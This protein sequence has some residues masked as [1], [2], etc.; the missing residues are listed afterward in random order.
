MHRYNGMNGRL[1]L[2]IGLVAL[3]FLAGC[4]QVMDV[5]NIIPGAQVEEGRP[6]SRGVAAMPTGGEAAP[7]VYA[8]ETGLAIPMVE[9]SAKTLQTKE[10]TVTIEVKTGELEGKLKQTQ[11]LLKSQG[12]L[13][14][15]IVYED[16]TYQ[17]R[18]LLT[19][20]IEPARFD[21]V[22]DEL[23][24]V[25]EVKGTNVNIE[26]VTRQHADLTIR[27]NNKQVELERLYQ[28]Y[29]RSESVEDLLQVESE[30]A[31]VTTELEQLK[32]DKEY[33][34]GRIARSTLTVELYE[35]VAPTEAREGSI[36]I[37]VNEGQLETTVL[38]LKEAV[39]RYDGSVKSIQFSETTYEKSYVLVASIVPGQRDGLV[40]DL[41]KLGK[42]TFMGTSQEEQNR[43]KKSLVVVTLT[44][45]KPAVQ[46]SFFVPLETLIQ[47]FFGALSTGVLILAGLTGFLLPGL[48]IVGIGYWFY[49]RRR[50]K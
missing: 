29:N 48:V 38:K 50:R 13:V 26:D 2:L 37:S 8:P 14:T 31:R 49:R 43:P 16:Y 18:Y 3:L 5:N 10:G 33:L 27:L 36:G 42:V 11:L 28:L 34:D 12:A 46:T 25:G 15:A 9:A 4:A 35:N 30:I 44:E 22:L 7:S 23:K 6:V 21:Q 40:D 19:T 17:K 32:S 41:R 1:G 20:G 24:S 39:A 47:T 45:S